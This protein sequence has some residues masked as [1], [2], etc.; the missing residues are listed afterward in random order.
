MVAIWDVQG[1]RDVRRMLS[2]FNLSGGTCLIK[3]NFFTQREGYYT[4]ART[5]DL[6]LGAIPGRKIVMECYTAARTDGSRAIGPGQAREHHDW[7]REQDRRFLAESGIGEIL[8]RHDAEFLNVTNV[9]EELW[10]GR[11]ADAREVAQLVERR[12]PPIIHSELYHCVPQQLLDLRAAPMLNLAK[13]KVV[14]AAT[15]AVF[16]SLAMKNLFGLI[17]EPDRS[18]YH[19]KG[20]DGLPGSIADMCKIYTALFD[21]THVAEAVCNT[22]ISREGLADPDNPRKGLGLICDLGLAVTGCDPVELDAFIVSQFGC[23][24]AQRHF[25]KLARGILGDWDTARFPDVPVRF[26]AFFARHR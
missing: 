7:L 19:G 1:G 18:G 16:F 20:R 14:N 24:P 23:D 15:D 3:P 2:C 11:A 17:P 22:L 5:L 8:A 26:A 21:V 6:F 4:D 25:L 12:Y 10:C 9:T 13:L